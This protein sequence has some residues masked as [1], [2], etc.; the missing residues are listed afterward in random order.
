MSKTIDL[1]VE[2]SHMLITGYRNNLKQLQPHGVTAAQ[3]DKMEADLKALQAA[4]EECEALRATLSGK[5]RRMNEI[6]AQVKQD[7][8]QQKHIVKSNY[9]IDQWPHYGIQDKR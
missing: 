3:L 9:G 6:L 4:G 8:L 5:V 7:F 2:K 1:Q